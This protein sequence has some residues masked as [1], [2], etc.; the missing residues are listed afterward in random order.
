M[1]KP[2]PIKID[3]GAL[4]AIVPVIVIDAAAH[5]ADLARALLAGGIRCAEV[6]LRTPA[7]PSAIR[8]MAGVPGFLVGAGT[9]RSAADVDVV[10]EAGARFVVTPGFSPSVLARSRERG[11]LAVPGTSTAT[12]LMAA[13]ELGIRHVKLFPAAALGGPALISLLAAPFPEIRFMPS[14]GVTEQ[15]APE[16]AALDSVFA[17][18]GSWMAPRALIA[19]R[20]FDEIT[21]ASAAALASLERR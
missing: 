15:N 11:V 17:V 4:G 20:G 14:G 12:D 3:A 13:L 16:Y 2:P 1:P 7:A 18:S 21:R 8:A 6:T 5:A 19:A 9:V 10:V